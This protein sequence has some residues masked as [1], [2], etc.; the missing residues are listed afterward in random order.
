LEAAFA[1]KP[2][3]VLADCGYD[4]IGVVDKAESWEVFLNWFAGKE[5]FATDLLERRH[6][7]STI[8][9]YFL[10]TGG[11]AF[12]NSELVEIG[13]GSWKVINFCGF[14]LSDNIFR[15]KYQNTI[16]KIK[17]LRIIRMINRG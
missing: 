10:A 4:E 3:I 2:S 12:N 14:K 16:S 8:R 9:G 13:W 17:F 1:R 11:L 6:E 5:K 7:N 15:V